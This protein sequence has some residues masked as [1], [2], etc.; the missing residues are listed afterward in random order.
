MTYNEYFIIISVCLQPLLL[1]MCY[2][3]SVKGCAPGGTR[4]R[5]HYAPSRVMGLGTDSRACLL[6]GTSS[7]VRVPRAGKEVCLLGYTKK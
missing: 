2:W 6:A 7:V 3:L 5:L 1:V 4:P